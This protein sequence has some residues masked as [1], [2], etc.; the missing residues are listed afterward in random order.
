MKMLDDPVANWVIG[1][2]VEMVTAQQLE[3]LGPKSGFK[4]SSSICSDG[5]QYPKSCDPPRGQCAGHCF[6]SNISLGECL[7]PPSKTID[8]GQQVG[9]S[10]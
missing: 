10:L 9:L 7:W 8:A 2:S 5:G 6:S 4:L 3:K 1:S